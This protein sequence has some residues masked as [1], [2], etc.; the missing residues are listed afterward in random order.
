MKPLNKIRVLVVDDHAIIRDGLRELLKGQSDIEVVG[1]AQEGQEALEKARSLRPDVMLLDIA[2]PGMNG[3]AVSSLM[4]ETSP[5]TRIIIFTMYK[6]EAYVQQAIQAGASGYV[7]KTSPSEEIIVAIR[8]VFAGKQFLSPDVKD[9]LVDRYLRQQTF[10]PK[11]TGY[12]SLSEREQRVFIMMIEGKSTKEMAEIL[13]LSPKTLE[14]Y[15]S[16]VMKKLH[17]RNLA[18]MTKYAIRAGILD[19]ELFD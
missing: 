18:E 1:Y 3:L 12:N 11:P 5:E 17:V 19:A 2:M 8:N 13:C 14:K 7:L 9:E 16:S 4:K 10:K 6:K 15:R